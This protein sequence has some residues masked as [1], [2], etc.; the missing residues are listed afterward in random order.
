MNFLLVFFS[1]YLASFS[2][3]FL[4]I[5]ENKIL[6]FVIY[7]Q[8]FAYLYNSILQNPKTPELILNVETIIK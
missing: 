5:P 4:S 8:Y 2:F 3:N 6:L 1:Y 7:P